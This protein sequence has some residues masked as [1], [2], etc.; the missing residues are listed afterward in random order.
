MYESRQ[1]PINDVSIFRHNFPVTLAVSFHV[2]AIAFQLLTPELN[3]A[4]SRNIGRKGKPG[5]FGPG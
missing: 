4:G 5:R 1:R 2:S 3:S